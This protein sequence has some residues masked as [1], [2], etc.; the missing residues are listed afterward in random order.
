MTNFKK[1]NSPLTIEEIKG[2]FAT[3][4]SNLLKVE[5]EVP[6]SLFSLSISEQKNVIGKLAVNTTKIENAHHVVVKAVAGS[7]PFLVVNMTIEIG[8]EGLE[9]LEVNET[10]VDELEGYMLLE[11]PLGSQE[12]SE[13]NS[14]QEV[15]LFAVRVPTSV[16]SR[17]ESDKK[18]F[19]LG[20]IS[21]D[22]KIENFDYMVAH[23]DPNDSNYYLVKV[24][25]NFSEIE[26]IREQENL[27]EN[28]YRHLRRKGLQL[29]NNG[30]TQSEINEALNSEKK[31]LKFLVELEQEDVFGGI[32]DAIFSIVEDEILGY[33]VSFDYKFKIVGFNNVNENIIVKIVGTLS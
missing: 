23:L 5:L 11:G 15:L 20:A 6:L 16:M 24:V 30:F 21:A 8:A 26:L 19:I 32:T 9:E 14:D 13:L 33:N 27:V 7:N 12:F 3:Q 1:I 31:E 10:P 22:F 17:S 28:Q 18:T 29:K 4:E 25:L 2:I